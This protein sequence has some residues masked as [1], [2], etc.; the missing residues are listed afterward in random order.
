MVVGRRLGRTYMASEM[1]GTTSTARQTTLEPKVAKNRFVV[2]T[3]FNAGSRKGRPSES[4]AKLQ[5]E[6]M[7]GE[8]VSRH[9]L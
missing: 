6:Q 5:L 9:S 4:K 1:S 8:K 7:L 2:Y 3:G